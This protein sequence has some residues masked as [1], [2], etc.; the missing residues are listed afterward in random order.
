MPLRNARCNDKDTI[1]IIIIIKLQARQVR[2][3]YLDAVFCINICT[4]L[5]N[6]PSVLDNAELRVAI[7]YVTHKI[8][9]SARCVKAENSVS[10]DVDIFR[11]PVTDLLIKCC[12]L[13]L[14]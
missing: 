12:M 3:Y 8:C 2:I 6:F 14:Y 9:T 11:K 13:C 4:G 10:G 7:H 1:I 5:K